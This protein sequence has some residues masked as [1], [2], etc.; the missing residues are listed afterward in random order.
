MYRDEEDL[1]EWAEYVHHE[2][3]D[4]IAEAMEAINDL[5]LTNFMQAPSQEREDLELASRLREVAERLERKW[6]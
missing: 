6:S 1:A 3:N 4:R 5:E 2:R